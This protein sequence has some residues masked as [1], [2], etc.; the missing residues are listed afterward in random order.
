[1]AIV[2][3]FNLGSSK[4]SL[5]EDA[6]LVFSKMAEKYAVNW[7]LIISGYVKVIGKI[8]KALCDAC[9][10]NVCFCRII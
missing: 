8:D 10:F 4:V 2:E 5:I 6:G 7:N 9:I 1:M 3:A